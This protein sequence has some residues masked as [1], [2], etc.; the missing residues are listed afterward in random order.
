M[1]V[2]TVK[3]TYR[4]EQEDRSLSITTESADLEVIRQVGILTAE[5]SDLRRELR[6]DRGPVQI[7]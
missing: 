3:A 6:A 1:S 2:W 5:M 4:L 7:S